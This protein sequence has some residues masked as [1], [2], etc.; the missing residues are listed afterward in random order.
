M[1]E[2]GELPGGGQR[3]AQMQALQTGLMDGLCIPARCG[4]QACF[5][6]KDPLLDGKACSICG[7]CNPQGNPLQ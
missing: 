4:D 3:R 7:G 1:T 6:Q 5:I 2:D